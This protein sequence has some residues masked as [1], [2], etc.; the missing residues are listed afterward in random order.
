MQHRPSCAMLS[1]ACI[2]RLP[3]SWCRARPSLPPS[4]T[5][6][7]LLLVR[8]QTASKSRRHHQLS[9]PWHVYSLPEQSVSVH[10]GVT[11]AWDGGGAARNIAA[12][13]EVLHTYGNLSDAQLLQTYGFVEE[14]PSDS[15]NPHNYVL[16]AAS[17]V[18]DCCQQQ[19]YYGC[20]V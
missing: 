4:P 18:I 8:P 5:F 10:F 3:A 16:V 7:T 20:L 11:S 2:L 19:V 15:L 14:L 17:D 6:S 1:F 9:I 13:E 12:G